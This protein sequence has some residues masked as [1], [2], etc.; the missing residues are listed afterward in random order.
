MK[1]T[2]DPVS[3]L[4]TW[5]IVAPADPTQGNVYDVM[6]L[7]T[8]GASP[9]ASATALPDVPPDVNPMDFSAWFEVFLGGKWISFDARHNVSRIGRILMATGRDAA[10]DSPEEERR[11]HGRHRKGGPVGALGLRANRYL[12]E[13]EP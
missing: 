2:V 13:R 9:G 12:A 3:E 7:P 11:D 8:P 10:G 5:T 1:L 6:P 4:A